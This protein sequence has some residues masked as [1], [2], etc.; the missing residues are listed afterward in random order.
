[1][2]FW[3]ARFGPCL[4]LLLVALLLGSVVAC[5]DTDEYYPGPITVVP[6]TSY[7]LP[8][9]S[10]AGERTDGDGEIPEAEAGP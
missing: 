1:M 2:L 7:A 10:P 4:T 3:K 6:D 5:D 8:R 9:H